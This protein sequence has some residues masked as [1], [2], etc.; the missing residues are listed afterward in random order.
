MVYTIIIDSMEFDLDKF[1]LQELLT[2]HAFKLYNRVRRQGG[3]IKF[4]LGAIKP[5]YRETLVHS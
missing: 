2:P 3:S 5:K 1:A 4:G